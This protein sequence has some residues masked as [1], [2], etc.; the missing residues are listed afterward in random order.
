MERRHESEERSDESEERSDES[1]ERSDES[2]ERSDD[3]EERSTSIRLSHPS[4]YSVS[5]HL[6]PISNHADAAHRKSS[7]RKSSL[8]HHGR[9]HSVEFNKRAIDAKSRAS[10]VILAS[11]M[12]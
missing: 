9:A 3:S 7:S 11:L 5:H 10:D 1:E 2:E 12:S 6:T 8:R 4:T